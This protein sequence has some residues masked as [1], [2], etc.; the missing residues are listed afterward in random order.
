MPG[1]FQVPSQDNGASAATAAVQPADLMD[2]RDDAPEPPVEV[3]SF[4]CLVFLPQVAF[5]STVDILLTPFA[6]VE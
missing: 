2:E 1:N 6:R 4:P 5:S 3:S